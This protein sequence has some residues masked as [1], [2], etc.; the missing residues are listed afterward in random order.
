VSVSLDEERVKELLKQAM[1]ELLEERRDYFYDLFA[2]VMEDAALA[3]AI[4]EGERTEAV[5]RAEW[6][7]TSP[8][9]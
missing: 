8:E 1:A 3:N 7:Q 5:D 6:G 2:E 9:L 4:G